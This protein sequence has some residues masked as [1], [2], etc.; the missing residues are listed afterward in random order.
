MSLLDEL[1]EMTTQ[2]INLI[3][4]DQKDLYT[5]FEL[6]I[7]NAEMEN[8][9]INELSKKV[10]KLPKELKCKKC[11]GLISSKNSICQFCGHKINLDE[12]LISEEYGDIEITKDGELNKSNTTLYIISFILPLIG[13]IL[14]LIYIGKNEDDLG[15]SLIIF[16]I[17]MSFILS[18]AYWFLFLA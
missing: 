1:K 15:K 12:F 17:V 16:S 14:G 7:I 2:D 10:F 11:D 3:L 5:E 9:K 18:I 13:I 4:C 6:E 8:R